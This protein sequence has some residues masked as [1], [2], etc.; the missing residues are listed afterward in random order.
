MP[1]R[2]GISWLQEQIHLTT[3]LARP[4]HK[5][6]ETA[7]HIAEVSTECRL[8]LDADEYVDS[9]KPFSMDIV[10]QWSQASLAMG[11]C[12]V[13]DSGQHSSSAWSH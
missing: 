6:Q 10:H 11:C 13:T 7:R 1:E 2:A 5:L 8:D 12:S 9:F 3:T 4:L